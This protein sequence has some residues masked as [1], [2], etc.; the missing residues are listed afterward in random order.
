MAAIGNT[1]IVTSPAVML[2]TDK[3]KRSTVRGDS[4]S[5]QPVTYPIHYEKHL[6]DIHYDGGISEF[7]RDGALP[8]VK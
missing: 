8:P 5:R 1:L 7:G 4:L 3:Q 2:V 6:A